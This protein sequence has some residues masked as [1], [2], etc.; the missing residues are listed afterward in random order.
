MKIEIRRQVPI[1]APVIKAGR[2]L[3]GSKKVYP[4]DELEIGDC[5]IV[6]L[7]SE[8]MS[9]LIANRHA[10]H[11]ERFSRRTIDGKQWVWR[12]A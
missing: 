12:I 6:K 9:S 8:R 11:R 7:S 10:S 3:A 4:W 1:P 2:N 5:F